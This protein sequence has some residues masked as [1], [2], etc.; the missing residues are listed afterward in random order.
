MAAQ[1]R[2]LGY[3]ASVGDR[4]A[5][6]AGISVPVFKADGQI[7]AAL[8]LTMPTHRYHERYIQQVLDAAKALDRRVG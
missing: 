4:L 2:S 8:T 5:E 1:V 6:V 3:C 7:A